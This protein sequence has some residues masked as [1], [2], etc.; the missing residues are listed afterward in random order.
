MSEAILW[1]D[2]ILCVGPTGCGKSTVVD[3]LFASLDGLGRRLVIDPADS[4]ATLVPGAKTVNGP[5]NDRLADDVVIRQVMT[6]L[7]QQRDAATLRFVP[8]DPARWS[9]YEGA[10]RWALERSPVFVWLDEAFYA[11]PSQ[12]KMPPAARRYLIWGRKYQAG[13]MA[14]HTRP[15]EIDRNL[16]VQ[17]AHVLTWRQPLRDDLKVLAE[18]FGMDPRDLWALMA[19]LE[20]ARLPDGTAHPTATGF[21]WFDRRRNEVTIQPPAELEP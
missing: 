19:E 9:E 7:E 1:Q 2:R 12:G 10:Y 13:H 4:Q 3:G 20:P 17:A 5:D 16:L 6:A 21:L 14:C 15:V 8:G 11:M 18:Q